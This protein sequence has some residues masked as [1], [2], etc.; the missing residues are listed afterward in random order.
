MLRGS[1]N[2][3]VKI[4]KDNV[5]FVNYLETIHSIKWIYKT[6]QERNYLKLL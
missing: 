4:E 1:F 5:S 6:T 2:E 3:F